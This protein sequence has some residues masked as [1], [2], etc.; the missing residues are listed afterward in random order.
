MFCPSSK[1]CLHKKMS[2]FLFWYS[3]GRQLRTIELRNI[4]SYFPTKNKKNRVRSTPQTGLRDKKH[5]KKKQQETCLR[6][7]KGRYHRPPPHKLYFL[8]RLGGWSF[9]IGYI[10]GWTTRRVVYDGPA[11]ASQHLSGRLGEVDTHA[12]MILSNDGEICARSGIVSGE[13]GI[14]S[15]SLSYR[16]V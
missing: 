7:M 9:E 3:C 16:Y 8:V 13:N 5:P 10:S 12:R 6:N 14:S 2:F 15:F 1:C 4:P 11:A